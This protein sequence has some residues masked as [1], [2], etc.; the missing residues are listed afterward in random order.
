MPAQGVQ[1]CCETMQLFLWR[2]NIVGVAH[3]IVACLD[4]P[5]VLTDAHDVVS[6]SS[7]SALA[8]GK[9]KTFISPGA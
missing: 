6:A 3:Y 9:M 1:F 5:G 8:A 4:A 7:S 2:R